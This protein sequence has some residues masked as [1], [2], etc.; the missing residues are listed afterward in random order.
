MQ[1]FAIPRT[2][3]GAEGIEVLWTWPDILPLST[4]GYD[5]LRLDGREIPWQ[6]TCETIGPPEITSLRARFE[7]AAPLGAL[8]LRRDSKLAPISAAVQQLGQAAAHAQTAPS[9]QWPMP[10]LAGPVSI[11][12]CLPTSKWKRVSWKRSFW[13]N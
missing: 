1:A 11:F 6:Q 9:A 7:I 2:D 4:Q 12:N 10:R 5:V 8:R 13:L 3:P